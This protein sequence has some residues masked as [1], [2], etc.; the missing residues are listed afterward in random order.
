MGLLPEKH[1]DRIAWV[2][3]RTS[4]W[5]T[6][7]TAIGT[8]TTQVTDVV[9]KAAA[10]AS[11]LSAQEVAQ[12]AAKAATDTLK[13]AMTAMTNSTMIV[14]EQVR[15]K[16]RTSGDSVYPLANI[17]VPA[18]PGPRPAPGKPFDL[19]V[20]LDETGILVLNWKCTNP[21]G[22]SGT[23]YQL[24]RRIGFDGE[25]VYIGGSGTREFTDET[26][27]AGSS[28]VTYQI[29]AWRSTTQGPAAQFNVN[30][31]VGPSGL[32]MTVASVT[33]EETA[34]LAA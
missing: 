14:V 17:P 25:F 21:Q 20:T 2:Q 13:A 7:A 26:L 23:I 28:M 24:W 9:T 10:A 16:A 12:N 30:F 6:N 8:T 15:T 31:G 34:K 1:A 4:L 11:A 27:P 29:V 5:T 18:V 19:K 22:T 33:P 32:G 3:S